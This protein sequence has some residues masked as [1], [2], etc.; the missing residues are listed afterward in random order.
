VRVVVF[1]AGAIGSLLGGRLARAGHSVLLVTRSDQA[2]RIRSDGLQVEGLTTG[3]FRPEVAT[4]LP[5]ETRADI[6]LLTVKSRSVRS[7]GRAIGTSVRPPAPVVA[8]QNGLAIEPEL[9]LGLTDGGWPS[10]ERW[11]V[12]GIN[13]YGA[14]LAAP[15]RVVHAGDGEILLPVADGN[16]PSGSVDRVEQLLKEGGFSVRRVENLAKELWRKAIVN[17]AINPVTADHGVRNGELLRDPWREQAERL[18]HEGELAARS[19]GIEFADRELELDLWRVVR[20]TA[21]NRSSMLQDLDRGRPTEVDQISGAILAAAQR[22]G[23]DLPWTRRAIDRIHRRET[24]ADAIDRWSD[25]G[26]APQKA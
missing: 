2:S 26:G 6:V 4:E 25:E 19:E 18:L 3:T 12:R 22:H 21:E 17:A 11:I 8:L 24:E 16:A 20:A 1:G 7:A 23:L 14:T 13:S 9:L 5:A 15:G 10:P